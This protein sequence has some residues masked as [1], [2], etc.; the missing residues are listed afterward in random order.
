MFFFVFLLKRTVPQLARMTLKFCK[1]GQTSKGLRDFIE[2]DL[3]DFT[4]SNPSVVIYLKPRYHKTAVLV[5]EYLDGS[6][7][8]QNLYKMPKEEIVNWLNLMITRSGQPIKVF[9]KEVATDWPSVQ[10]PWN[11]FLNKP[12]EL[13]VASFPNANRSAFIPEKKSASQRLIELMEQQKQLESNQ[14]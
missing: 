2:Q 7:H 9:D 14:S 5:C 1:T 13:N 4:R 12:S 3:I 8:W 11:P 10:G 6:Y